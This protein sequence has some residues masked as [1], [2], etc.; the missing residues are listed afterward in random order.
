MVSLSHRA[1]ES[2]KRE[3]GNAK[4]ETRNSKPVCEARVSTLDFSTFDLQWLNDT[5]V[6]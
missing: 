3:T 1:I 4:F 5:I 6:Q 2:L